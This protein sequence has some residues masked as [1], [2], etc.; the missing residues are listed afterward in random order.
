[1]PDDKVSVIIPMFN[2]S[3]YSKRCLAALMETTHR[4]LEIVA[5]DNGSTDE[6]PAVLAEAGK[7]ARAAGIELTVI[8]NDTNRGASTARNQGL[9]AATG[10]YIAVMDNDIV[11]RRRS[12]A[13]TMLAALKE[14][15]DVGIVSP[16]IMFAFPPHLIQCAGAAV[17]PTGRVFF[18]G[19]GEPADTPQFNAPR[20]LQAAISA[21]WMMPAS[22]PRQLGGFDE[23]YNPVQYED[24]DFAYRVRQAGYKILYLPHVEM[25]HFENVTTG[26]SPTLNSTY[27][28]IRN[29]MEFKRR[30]RSMYTEEGGPD[31][32]EFDWKKIEKVPLESIGSLD[33]ID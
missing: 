26:R 28:I 9:D 18:L 29:G 11:I 13:G 2:K 30:W 15:S 1:M 31:D 8:A 19:R 10:D 27:L 16:K 12:W 22:I 24:I 20:E 21:C 25:Y 7:A 17:S 14:R 4:P 33:L 23:I 5:I 6:T 32:R 3:F